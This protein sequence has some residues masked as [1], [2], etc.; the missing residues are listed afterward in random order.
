MACF[1][2]S[3]VVAIFTTIFGRKVPEKYKI[4][5][6][7]LLLWGGTLMLAIEHIAHGEIVPYFPFLTA[8]AEGPEAVSGMLLE[9]ATIGIPMLLVC[10]GIW[11]VMVVLAPKVAQ[12]HPEAKAAVAA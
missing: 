5:W 2:V 11:A 1:L 7:N 3:T 8:V 9:M 6:L 10:V 12:Y 4:G